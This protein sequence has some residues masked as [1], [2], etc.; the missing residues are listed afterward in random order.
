[1]QC[2]VIPMSTL[3]HVVFCNEA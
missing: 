1:M 2:D 3:F